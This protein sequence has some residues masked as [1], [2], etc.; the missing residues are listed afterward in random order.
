MH[1]ILNWTQ[2]YR[3][4]KNCN[5][6]GYGKAR[7]GK[8]CHV[9]VHNCNHKMEISVKRNEF[10]S[11]LLILCYQAECY[12]ITTS[13]HWRSVGIVCHLLSNF[14]S[15]SFLFTANGIKFNLNYSSTLG[16]VDKYE[17][18][19]GVFHFE[20]AWKQ[21]VKITNSE[22]RTIYLIDMCNWCTIN[23]IQFNSI[24]SNV[25]RPFMIAMSV[26]ATSLILLH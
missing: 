6:N 23:Q 11:F 24:E 15:Y 5:W 3:L 14:C 21:K 7:Q 4:N 13:H 18:F 10:T 9:C 22:W 25:L 17:F 26:R 2:L 19:F 16:P 12:G 20:Q 8:I 1:S